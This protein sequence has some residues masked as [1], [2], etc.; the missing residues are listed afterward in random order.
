MVLEGI[1]GSGTTTQVA[2]LRTS[3]PGRVS[4]KTSPAASPAHAAAAIQ[5]ATFTSGSTVNP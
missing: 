2:R 1:D 3:L 5:A 4:K